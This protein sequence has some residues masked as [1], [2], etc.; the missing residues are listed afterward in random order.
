MGERSVFT[1]NGQVEGQQV[2]QF[3]EAAGITSVLRGESLTR[4][5]GLSISELGRVDVYVAEADAEQARELLAAVERGDL[6]LADEP[7]PGAE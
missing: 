7:E 5:H 1:A 6:R 4:T 3:L 2:Q